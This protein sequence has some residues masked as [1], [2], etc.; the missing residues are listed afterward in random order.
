MK[1]FFI[2]V[3]LLLLHFNLYAHDEVVINN[4]SFKATYETISLPQGTKPMGLMG[5]NY[6]RKIDT[7]FYYGASIYGSM[8]GQRGGFFSGGLNLGYEKLLNENIAL[9]FGV[10]VGAGSGAGK[11]IFGEG[12]MQ[13]SY[14]GF[15]YNMNDYKIGSYVSNVRFPGSDTNSNQLGFSLGMPFHTIQ[16]NSRDSKKIY[17]SLSKYLN[18][19]NVKWQDHYYA[20]TFEKYKLSSDA[21]GNSN[22]NGDLSLIGFEIRQNINQKAFYYF[23]AAEAISGD[24]AGYAQIFGGFGYANPLLSSFGLISKVGIGS[25]G[26]SGVDVGGGFL[27]KINTG[28][29]YKLSKKLNFDYEVGYID[30]PQG[31]LSGLSQKISLSYNIPFLTTV[32]NGNTSKYEFKELSSNMWRMRVG[33]QRYLTTHYT[34]RS[35]TQAIDLLSFKLDR[36]LNKHLYF[37]GQGFGVY[38]GNAAGYGGG[39]VGLGMQN[40]NLIKDTSLYSELLFG[41]GGAG[42]VDTGEGLLFEGMLGINYNISKE[43]DIQIGVGQVKALSGGRLNETVFDLSLVYKFNTLENS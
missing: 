42:A 33:T 20:L 12:L 25:G 16:T 27:Y 26:G 30:A 2:F 17:K 3:V 8:S 35:S 43:Y 29:Y 15:N 24:S 14:L 28:V 6:Q 7:N 21:L 40:S 38:K 1:A 4:D 23:E 32:K 19:Y 13:R 5:I 41:T 22:T 18:D 36:Y 10:F 37:S 34:N 39:F 9:D 11:D 31:K